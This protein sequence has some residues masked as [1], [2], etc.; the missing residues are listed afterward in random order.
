[1]KINHALTPV[2]RH[3]VFAAA[4]CED[5]TVYKDCLSTINP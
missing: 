3:V 2:N 1:M 5:T 4:Y